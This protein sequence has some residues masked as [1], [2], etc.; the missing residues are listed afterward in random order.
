MVWKEVS[1]Y[2]LSLHEEAGGLVEILREGRMKGSLNVGG[3]TIP[4]GITPMT[5]KSDRDGV[6]P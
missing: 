4:P 1:P 3:E 6:N 2:T 5:S